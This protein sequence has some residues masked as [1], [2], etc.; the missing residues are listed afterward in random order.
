MTF[1]TFSYCDQVSEGNPAVLYVGARPPRH[2]R[3]SGVIENIFV[4]P[5][6]FFSE[7]EV[8]MYHNDTAGLIEPRG[9]C[10]N[11]LQLDEDCPP[12]AQPVSLLCSSVFNQ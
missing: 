4:I 9:M 8:E 1:S 10:V 2:F 3:F 12:P 5:D 6:E 11:Y 7:A